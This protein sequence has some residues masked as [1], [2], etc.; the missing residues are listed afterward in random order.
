M[1]ERGE[2]RAQQ[3]RGSDSLHIKSSA[4]IHIDLTQCCY[5]VKYLLLVSLGVT[6]QVHQSCGQNSILLYYSDYVWKEFV[7]HNVHIFCMHVMPRLPS[8]FSMHRAFS[9]CIKTYICD[10]KKFNPAVALTF[11]QACYKWT[12][13]FMTVTLA[14]KSLLF[15]PRRHLRNITVKQ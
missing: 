4:L 12:K 1:K 2:K 8:I 11:H 3:V 15:S 13:S 5:I 7:M 14:T 6:A 10:Y 9:F